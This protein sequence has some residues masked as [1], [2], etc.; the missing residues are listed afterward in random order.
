MMRPGSR[1]K[2]DALKLMAR[3]TGGLAIL[4]TNDIE[5]GLERIEND[6]QFYYSLG[7]KSP[8][9]ED[10][11]Y[12]SI[13]VK[14]AGIK[15]KYK[16]RVRQGYVR[17]SQEEKVKE[18]VFSRLHLK[19]QY[20]PMNVMVQIMLLLF[21]CNDVSSVITGP[22]TVRAFILYEKSNCD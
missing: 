15:E 10:N 12:H 11:K 6:L 7:Y 19:R 21:I 1:V 17:I 4:N 16:V 8:H 5:S 2:N 18:S 9:R 14:L 22:V 3:E 13:K 20:N